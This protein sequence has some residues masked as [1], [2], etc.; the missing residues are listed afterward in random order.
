MT[1]YDRLARLY[2]FR[3]TR[4]ADLTALTD[5]C[6]FVWYR[7][8]T[9]VFREGSPADNALLVVSGRLVVGFPDGIQELVIGDVRPGEVTGERALVAPG[10]PRGADLYAQEDT[11]CLVLSPA[12]M[13][14]LARNPAVQAIERHLLGTMARRVLQ[15]NRSHRRI[16]ATERRSA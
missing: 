9:C 8:G 2:L 5:R 14:E 13:T 6:R 12:V 11:L 4:P 15:N 16:V 1:P 3:D 7:V 10:G